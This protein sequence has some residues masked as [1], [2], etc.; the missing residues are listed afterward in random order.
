MLMLLLTARE[1]RLSANQLGCPSSRSSQLFA[2]ARQAGHAFHF[3]CFTGWVVAIP[4]KGS[5][6]DGAWITRHPEVGFAP[7]LAPDL[8]YDGLSHPAKLV[9]DGSAKRSQK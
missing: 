4:K 3:A 2:G 8:G 5:R 9:A 6:P 7:R 1:G